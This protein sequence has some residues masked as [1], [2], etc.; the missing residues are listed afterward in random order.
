[1]RILYVGSVIK[2]AINIVAFHEYISK[3]YTSFP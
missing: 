3:D 1:M 2:I